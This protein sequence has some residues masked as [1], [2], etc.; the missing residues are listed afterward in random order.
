MNDFKVIFLALY[1]NVCLA[2]LLPRWKTYLR[3]RKNANITNIS[4]IIPLRSAASRNECWKQWTFPLPRVDKRHVSL[5]RIL[6]HTL[7]RY[8]YFDLPSALSYTQYAVRQ[9]CSLLARS[10]QEFY[11]RSL[12][13]SANNLSKSFLLCS[14][15]PTPYEEND[16]ILKHLLANY[17]RN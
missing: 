9:T 13:S 17:T 3:E 2:W 15:F 11:K 7:E 5:H 12:F 14:P 8:P 6:R 16:L 4:T 10:R 1:I